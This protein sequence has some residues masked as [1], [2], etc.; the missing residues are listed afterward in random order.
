MEFSR[1]AWAQ[2]NEQSAHEKTRPNGG[3]SKLNSVDVEVDV[4]SR[5][6]RASDG[7]RHLTSPDACRSK[8]S[9]IP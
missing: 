6:A 7:L 3:L 2:L 4:V 9:G 1:C 5:R 8:S